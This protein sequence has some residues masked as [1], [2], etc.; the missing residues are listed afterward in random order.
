M[1]KQRCAVIE[2]A[3]MMHNFLEWMGQDVHVVE[4]TR[5]LR[6]GMLLMGIGQ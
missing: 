6:T 5:G 2:H 3:V 1:G 4:P